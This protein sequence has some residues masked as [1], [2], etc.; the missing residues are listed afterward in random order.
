[1]YVENLYDHA[2]MIESLH[3]E[4][5]AAMSSIRLDVFETTRFIE[6]EAVIL[7]RPW[8][9]EIPSLI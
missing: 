2:S 3:R 4:V 9:F 6:H 8:E 7:D 5:V 1:M